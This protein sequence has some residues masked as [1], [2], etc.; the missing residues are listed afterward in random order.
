MQK[1][2]SSLYS[3]EFLFSFN[4]HIDWSQ[5]VNSAPLNCGP[6]LL[7]TEPDPGTAERGEAGTKQTE[8]DIEKG[9]G[10]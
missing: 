5:R 2:T 9:P 3:G 6:T 8:E 4:T 7:H 1:A 10:G